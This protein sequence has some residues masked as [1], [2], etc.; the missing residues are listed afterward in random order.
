[1]NCT[2][3]VFQM[4][5]KPV[6]AAPSHSRSARL[7][8]I[9]RY[10]PISLKR[11]IYR[12]I[13][14][15]AIFTGTDRFLSSRVQNPVINHQDFD[16]SSWLEA[17]E[18]K[19]D[20]PGLMAALFWPPQVERG[21][22]YVHLFDSNNTPIGFAKIS[23]SDSDD[24]SLANEAQRLQAFADSGL[25]SFQVPRVI[26]FQ[27]GSS[28]QHAVLLVEPIPTDAKPL[29]AQFSSFPTQCIDEIHS[30]HSTLGNTEHESHSWWKHYLQHRD[31][32]NPKFVEELNDAQI[33]QS[34][35]C[36]VHGDF[37][38]PNIV[39]NPTGELWVFDWEE[40]CDSGPI[41]TDEL[42]FYWSVHRLKSLSDRQLFLARFKEHFLSND[43]PQHRT[44]LMLAIAFY[45]TINPQRADLIISNWDQF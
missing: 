5:G 7:A 19:L 42:S 25:N 15:A 41:L 31:S 34:P 30:Q 43:D 23:F 16:F 32:F 9:A 8:G 44:N 36:R 14:Q 22:I 45:S 13:M 11:S 27:P 10:Q 21:R 29:K 2:Y 6:F 40:C 37:G 20:T 28:D 1:M 38:I 3:R 4:S 12:S 35:C 26:D 17:I 24:D 33:K 18:V 39:K